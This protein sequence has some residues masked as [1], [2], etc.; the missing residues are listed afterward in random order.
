MDITYFASSCESEFEFFPVKM[1]GHADEWIVD[2]R[3]SET[4][5]KF[6]RLLDISST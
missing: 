4:G 2:F 3:E 6:A 5:D 1:L